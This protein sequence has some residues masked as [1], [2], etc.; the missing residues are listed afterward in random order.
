MRKSKNQKTNQ[1][2]VAFG[3]LA[4]GVA[5]AS[6][7]AETMWPQHLAF[8]GTLKIEAIAYDGYT[9]DVDYEDVIVEELKL[10]IGA[11]LSERLM[12]EV[13]FLY[14]EDETD[15]GVDIA[16]LHLALSD[17]LT[18]S[19]GQVYIPFGRYEMH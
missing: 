16:V 19:A 1:A 10:G 5:S 4:L 12:A 2:L 8:G 14:E 17:V 3:A 15:F 13:G 6:A 11:T 9:S 18:V 7:Q